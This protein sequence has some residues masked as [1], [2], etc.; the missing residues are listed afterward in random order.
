MGIPSV[1]VVASYGDIIV[2]L[3]SAASDGYAYGAANEGFD[4]ED[5]ADCQICHQSIPEPNIMVRRKPQGLRNKQG[6]KNKKGY[7]WDFS[8]DEGGDDERKKQDDDDDSE[9]EEEEVEQVKPR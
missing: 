6:G 1:I 2:D 4:D 3:D 8:D 7:Q 5:G 9:E